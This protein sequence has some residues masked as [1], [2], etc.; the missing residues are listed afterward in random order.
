MRKL[1]QSVSFL[2]SY[3]SLKNKYYSFHNADI[4]EHYDQTQGHIR[5]T[6]YGVTDNSTIGLEFLLVFF[7]PTIYINFKKKNS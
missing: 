4:Y 7:R 5:S 6:F 1:H 2:I 3:S